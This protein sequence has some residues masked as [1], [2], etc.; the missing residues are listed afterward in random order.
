MWDSC[1]LVGKAVSIQLYWLL[2]YHDSRYFEL[3][4]DTASTVL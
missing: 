2:H 4:A 3:S 1:E